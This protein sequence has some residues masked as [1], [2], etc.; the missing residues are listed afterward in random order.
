MNID[1][2]KWNV[3]FIEQFVL[4]TFKNRYSSGAFYIILFTHS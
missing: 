4:V 1:L 2:K 3:Y